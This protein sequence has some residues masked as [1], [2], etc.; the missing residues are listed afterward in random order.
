MYDENVCYNR[1]MAR[2]K[3]YKKPVI[4]FENGIPVFEYAMPKTPFVFFPIKD[5]EQPKDL[6]QPFHFAIKATEEQ[7]ELLLE[8]RK[9][10]SHEIIMAYHAYIDFKSEFPRPPNPAKGIGKRAYNVASKKLTQWKLAYREFDNAYKANLTQQGWPGRL[11]NTIIDQGNAKIDSSYAIAKRELFMAK[12]RHKNNPSNE[13]HCRIQFWESKTRFKHFSLGDKEHLDEMRKAIK[14]EDETARMVAFMAWEESRLFPIICVGGGDCE[15]KWLN[16]TF[17]LRLTEK[18][19][20]FV[21]KYPVFL[22]ATASKVEEERQALRKQQGKSKSLQGRRC[23]EMVFPVKLD[24]TASKHWNFAVK[25]KKALTYELSP[26]TKG[27]WKCTGI[28]KEDACKRFAV[29]NAR[30][31]IDQNA[32]FI[33]VALIIG[34]CV[35]WV[36]KYRISQKGSTEQHEQRIQEVMQEICM[37]AVKE[38][39]IIVL[40]DLSLAHVT[41]G[42]LN[43]RARQKINRIPYRKT[44][45]ILERVALRE[46]AT[47]HIVNPAYTSIL[48]RFRLPGMSVHLAAACLIAWRDLGINQ[49]TAIQFL[50]AGSTCIK[51][52]VQGEGEE[53]PIVVDIKEGI[54]HVQ[55]NS[56]DPRFLMAFYKFIESVYKALNTTQCKDD[57]AK[58]HNLEHE[59]PKQRLSGWKKGMEI[60][61]S[62]D[63]GCKVVHEKMSTAAGSIPKISVFVRLK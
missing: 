36:K 4:P 51:V 34:N 22:D 45:E 15:G 21:L 50:Y 5:Y 40:E 30:L 39:A 9:F 54:R 58:Q 11:A 52:Q 6:Y 43:T 17:F 27:K 32:G 8:V 57:S 3:T 14:E 56:A 61:Q 7:N 53:S 10:Y 44:Q 35:L 37:H 26:L 62:H 60:A 18:G 38:K 20:E 28:Y 31:G 49:E 42:Y 63:A 2:I 55:S 46:G 12:I 24:A 23:P 47:I 48:G 13:T 16:S 25:H 59:A 41:K 29:G 19:T 33:T 1:H